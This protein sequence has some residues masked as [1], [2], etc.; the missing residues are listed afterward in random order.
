MRNDVK[1]ETSVPRDVLAELKSVVYASFANRF[2]H[3]VVEELAADDKG[4]CEQPNVHLGAICNQ[5]EGINDRSRAI[6]CNTYSAD[7]FIP[8]GRARWYF[9]GTF[10]CAGSPIHRAKEPINSDE[11]NPF[12]HDKYVVND[13]RRL[14]T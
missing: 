5:D 4:S 14:I 7:A 6:L 1:G 9:P 8:Q 2:V 3:A 12:V 13:T 10:G 11:L